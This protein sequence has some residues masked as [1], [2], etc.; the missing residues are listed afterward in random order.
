MKAGSLGN[1]TSQTL[2]VGIPNPSPNTTT[3]S[4]SKLL[5]VYNE[6]GSLIGSIDASG[7]AEFNQIIT[8]NLIIASNQINPDSTSSAT[9]D[10]NTTAASTTLPANQTSIK[11]NNSKIK[12]S[13]LIYLTPLS[14]TQNQVLFVSQKIPQDSFVVSTNQA[15]STDIQFNYWLIQT[16]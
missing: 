1:L 2:Q 12:N 15:I 7:S 5:S 11:I 14:D 16:K 4:F 10:S 6:S 3:G 9:T 13:T 8:P